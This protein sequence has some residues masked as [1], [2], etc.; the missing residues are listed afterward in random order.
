M[1]ES[2]FSKLKLKLDLDN[3]QDIL[4]SPHQLQR[5][6]AFSIEGYANSERPHSTIGYLNSINYEKQFITA[7][8]LTPVNH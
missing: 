7:H 4:I 5:N 1:V 6:L 3:I 8:T 2:F